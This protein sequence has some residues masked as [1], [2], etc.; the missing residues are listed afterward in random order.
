MTREIA[1]CNGACWK[2]CAGFSGVMLLL[3]I[4]GGSILAGYGSTPNPDAMAVDCPRYDSMCCMYNFCESDGGKLAED[5][6]FGCNT[7][8]HCYANDYGE[9][10]LNKCCKG[11]FSCGSKLNSLLTAV[12]CLPVG[13]MWGFISMLALLKCCCCGKEV[14]GGNGNPGVVQAVEVPPKKLVL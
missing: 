13:G 2:G 6:I 8:D 12:I 10:L 1:C 7:C 11:A 14:A 3:G 4:I 9:E 5:A